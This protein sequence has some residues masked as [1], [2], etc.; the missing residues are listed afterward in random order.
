MPAIT[1]TAPIAA[2]IAV[3]ELPASSAWSSRSCF[4]GWTVTDARRERLGHGPRDLVGARRA[5]EDAAP[6]GHQQEPLGGLRPA[7]AGHGHPGDGAGR[8]QGVDAL[9]VR[10]IAESR[11]AHAGHHAA[12]LQGRAPAVRQDPHATARPDAEGPGGIRLQNDLAGT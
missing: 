9:G 1:A 7:G 4:T 3:K 11:A 6:V 5:S 10:L 2:R 12:H 8:H